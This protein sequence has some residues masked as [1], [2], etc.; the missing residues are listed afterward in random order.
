MTDL[1]TWLR[2]WPW[3]PGHFDVRAFL[4]SDGRPLVQVRLELGILQMEADGRPDGLRYRDEASALAWFSH[5]DAGPL[6]TDAVTDL[7]TE[8]AQR[9]RRMAAC[10]ALQ[11]WTRVRRDASDNLAALDL[12]AARAREPDDRTRLEAWRVHEVAMRARAEAGIALTVGRRDL[13]RRAVE[14]GLAAVRDACRDG[15]GDGGPPLAMLLE[16]LD[17]LTLK[18]PSSQRVELEARL[19]AAVQAE[20]FELAAILRDELRLLGGG[21]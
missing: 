1:S 6:A 3:R 9:R 8:M 5:E 10:A 15:H 17:A 12:V 16:V 20:N 11:D 19:R 4:A 21:A 2:E 7:A 14:T 13:A 18:L